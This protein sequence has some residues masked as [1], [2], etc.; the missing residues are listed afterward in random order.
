MQ[1][2]QAWFGDN[3]L[4]FYRRDVDTAVLAMHGTT[5]DRQLVRAEVGDTVQV[6]PYEITVMGFGYAHDRDVVEVIV[7]VPA[8][9][10]RNVRGDEGHDC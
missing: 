8:A 10:H 3:A 4:A 2:T 9:T 5:M 6:G 7:S 1:A